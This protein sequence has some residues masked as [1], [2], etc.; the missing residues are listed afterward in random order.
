MALL[1]SNSKLSVERTDLPCLEIHE[2]IKLVPL[3]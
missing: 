3:V 2:K 1:S